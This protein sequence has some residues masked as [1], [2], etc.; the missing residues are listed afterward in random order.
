MHHYDYLKT[1]IGEKRI[2]FWVQKRCF[3]RFWCDSEKIID[4]NVTI[5]KNGSINT[6]LTP[7][8]EGYRKTFSDLKYLAG[9]LAVM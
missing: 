2:Q 3:G 6:F 5:L 7:E 8:F 9:Q 1:R 4:P